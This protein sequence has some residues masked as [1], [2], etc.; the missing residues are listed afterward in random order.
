MRREA[1][2]RWSSYDTISNQ[3]K[4]CDGSADTVH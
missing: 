1:Q 2:G 3:L 4:A